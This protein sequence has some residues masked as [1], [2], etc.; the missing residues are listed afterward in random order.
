MTPSVL[1]HHYDLDMDTT[2]EDHSLASDIDNTDTSLDNEVKAVLGEGISD[3]PVLPPRT[4][5]APPLPPRQRTSDA[6]PLPP[7]TPERSE[8]PSFPSSGG[9]VLPI[10]PTNDSVV[11]REPQVS[12]P[13]TP[14][15]RS[16]ETPEPQ[17][18]APQVASSNMLEPPPPPLP[19]RTYS[20]VNLA[21]MAT[22]VSNVDKEQDK[23]SFDSM[24]TH[25]SS[26]ENPV[27]PDCNVTDGA[28]GS[29]KDASRV[30]VLNN[31]S[32]SQKDKSRVVTNGTAMPIPEARVKPRRKNR[33]DFEQSPS[34]SN[35][36][37]A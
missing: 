5:K 31:T 10:L 29:Q 14:T 25:L 24:E 20:P 35:D 22:P 18:P 11:G 36:T 26:E 37:F 1:I 13:Q 33:S 6:P 7:R 30:P 2:L 28:T 21:T 3:P 8:K 9:G 15:P 23:N 17:I 32:G 34:D 12:G 27:R 4:Y 16:L 19:P